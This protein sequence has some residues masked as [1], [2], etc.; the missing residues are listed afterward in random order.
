MPTKGIQYVSFKSNNPILL[1]YFQ[2]KVTPLHFAATIGGF[3]VS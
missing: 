2:S 1:H 3:E